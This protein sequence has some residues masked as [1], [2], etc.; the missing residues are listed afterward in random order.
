[1]ITIALF[2]FFEF[3][4]TSNCWLTKS[5][6]VKEMLYLFLHWNFISKRKKKKKKS[7]EL[8][9]IVQLKYVMGFEISKCF[10]SKKDVLFFFFKFCFKW[11]V[12]Y[13][14]IISF[15]FFFLLGK[16]DNVV[17][18]SALMTFS[19]SIKIC[20]VSSILHV[21]YHWMLS[22]SFTLKIKI[23]V[24]LSKFFYA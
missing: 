14:Y 4:I 3:I 7:T 18:I 13:P 19:L 15:F 24:F 10:K 6:V 16:K 8:K 20:I 1:M 23:F 21:H 11:I 2:V 9:W 12:F 17:V 22:T 5:V